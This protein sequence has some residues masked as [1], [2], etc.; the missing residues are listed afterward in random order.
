MDKYYL[1]FVNGQE[2]TVPIPGADHTIEN[3]TLS[4]ICEHGSLIAYFPK[5]KWNGF[6]ID[7]I[8]LSEDDIPELPN[9]TPHSNHGH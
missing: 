2:N 3:D 7:H 1:V 8:D 9:N 5:D 6:M 4:I